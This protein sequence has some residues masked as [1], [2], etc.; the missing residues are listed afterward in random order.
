MQW[1]GLF[2][3]AAKIAPQ[4]GAVAERINTGMAGYQF[5]EDRKEPSALL[6]GSGVPISPQCRS[7]V[8][9]LGDIARPNINATLVGKK[10]RF[11]GVCVTCVGFSTASRPNSVRQ[12]WLA[13]PDV[14]N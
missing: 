2:G 5:S 8:D 9:K 10:G 13:L 6:M 3:Q 12:R 7:A 14:L 1:V 4:R 11:L